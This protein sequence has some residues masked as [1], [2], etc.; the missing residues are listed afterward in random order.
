MCKKTNPVNSTR[1]GWYISFLSFK[2]PVICIFYI[3]FICKTHHKY[4]TAQ[5]ISGEDINCC[6]KSIVEVEEN[7]NPENRKCFSTPI[8][9][10]P[11][12]KGDCINFLRSDPI[13]KVKVDLLI[14]LNS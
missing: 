3:D 6:D 4:F 13:Y 10:D 12:L 5:G 2:L 14:K 7:I 11:V 8:L 1:Q 9:S